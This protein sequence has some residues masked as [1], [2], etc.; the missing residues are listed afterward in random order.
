MGN[1]SLPVSILK[2]YSDVVIFLTFSLTLYS[3][4]RKEFELDIKE[5][6]FCAFKGGGYLS[7]AFLIHRYY[8]KLD[9]IPVLDFFTFILAAF[10][11]GHNL[12]NSIGL[13]IAGVLKLIYLNCKGFL[14]L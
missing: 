2:G 12:V 3:V 13:L 5:W 4:F 14:S 1:L 7:L 11:G 8:V 10:E 6:L 9:T